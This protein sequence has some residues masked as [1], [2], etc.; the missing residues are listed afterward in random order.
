MNDSPSNAR[1]WYQFS[2]RELFLWVL[3]IG[4]AAVLLNSCRKGM[5]LLSDGEFADRVA[6]GDPLVQ[7]V[8][9]YKARTGEWPQE[10][11]PDVLAGAA[12]PGYHWDY[13]WR[14]ET[15]PP[16]LILWPV[17]HC[18]ATYQF[19]D[20]A[21]QPVQINNDWAISGES[22]RWKSVKSKAI[23][24]EQMDSAADATKA[25]NP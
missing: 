15:I 8:Y 22:V 10:L 25:L 6:Q 2:L 3:F 17:M 14:D 23:P 13:L 7:A 21:S 16:K 11:T 4:V 19:P 20:Y 12:H 9:D 1:P 24:P 5:G 18:N